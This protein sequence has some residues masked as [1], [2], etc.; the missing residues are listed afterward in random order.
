[1][2]NIWQ[3]KIKF[4]INKLLRRCCLYQDVTLEL[5]VDGLE[6]GTAKG[7]SFLVLVI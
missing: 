1:M 5:Q 3:Q 7:S 2:Y 6:G 4:K